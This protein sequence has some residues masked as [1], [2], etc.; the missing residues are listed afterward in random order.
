MVKLTKHTMS[1]TNDP[2]SK[3]VF[4]VKKVIFFLSTIFLSAQ[5][6]ALS[7]QEAIV[8]SQRAPLLKSLKAK[9]QSYKKHAQAQKSLNYPSLELSYGALYLKEKPVMYFAGSALQVQSQNQYKGSIKL[10]Y[11]L[12][13][14]FAFA[15][16][17]DKAT[18]AAKRVALEA[19]DTKRN[20]YL[21]VVRLYTSALS[22]AKLIQS[23]KVAYNATKQSYDKAKAYHE[24]GLIAESELYR[25]EASLSGS[26]SHL[27][28]MKNN[29]KIALIQLSA[30][31]GR[32]VTEVDDLGMV[33]E[34]KLDDLLKNALEKRPDI[35]AL[36]MMLQEQKAQIILAK[37]SYYPSVLLFA[38]ASQI[39]D[40]TALNGDGYTNKDRSAV[41]FLIHY[42]LFDG[43]KTTRE[44]EAA[45]IAKFATEEM[46]HYYKDKVRSELKTSYANFSSLKSRQKA[47]R[48]Q[49][50]AQ[51]SYEKLVVAEFENQLADGDKLARAIAAS[52]LIRADLITIDAELYNTYARILLEVD[53]N[54]FLKVL[55][56]QKDNSDD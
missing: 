48:A 41:G 10:T 47:L 2:E 43:L 51:E 38:E 52:A 3:K 23:E 50:K 35:L 33:Q 40:T 15:S 29:Y 36:K 28:E 26:S 37:S 20:L 55:H 16:L 1:I 17:I 45:K 11:P 54:S 24:L 12:F 4:R 5:L 56:L 25:I 30:A 42:N 21:N 34:K 8:Y 9:T 31:I 44:L 49:L 6:F 19:E 53:N 27:I 46:L 7:L 18:Y 32:E 22:F 14:G 13:E 39:G